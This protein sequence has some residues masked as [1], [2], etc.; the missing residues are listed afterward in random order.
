VTQLSV[1]FGHPEYSDDAL[2]E[3]IADILDRHQTLAMATV[4]EDRSYTKR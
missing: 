3:S 4:M 2:R 1:S